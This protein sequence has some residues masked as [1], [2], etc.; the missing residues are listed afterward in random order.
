MTSPVTLKEWLDQVGLTRLESTFR[1]N[2]VDLDILFSLTDGDL[3]ELGLTLGD[4]KRVLAAAAAA[5]LA[6]SQPSPQP[7]SAAREEPERRQ[8]TMVFCDLVG[9][10]SLSGRLDPEDMHAVVQAYQDAC[11]GII[12]RYDGYVANFMGD[13]ILAY[14]GYPRAHEDDAARAAR[15]GL[16]IGAAIGKLETHAGVRLQVRV[17]IAT[18]VVVVNALGKGSALGDTPNLAARL[19]NL[20]RPGSVVIARATR[21]LLGEQF[22]LQ[23]IGTHT[24]KGFTE[25]VEAWSV[26]GLAASEDSAQRSAEEGLTPLVGREQEIAVLLD[27]WRLAQ[28]GTGQV[29]LLSGEPGIGKTRLLRALRGKLEALGA[30]TLRNQCSP[31]Y[32]NSAFWPSID[33]LEQTLQFGREEPPDSRLDKLEGFMVDRY[34]RPL[35]D[36]RF[37]A[38]LLSIPC[39]QRYGL[40]AMTPQKQKEETLRVLVDL[41]EAA[42]RQRPAL[43]V[44]EDMHWADPT[45][46]EVLDLLIERTKGA[47]LLLVLTYRPEFQP[48][49]TPQEHISQ[50]TL[51]RLDAAQS[52]AMVLGLTAGKPL[53]G[54]LP[55]RILTKTDGVPLF[56]EELTK[57]ILESGELKDT[58]DRYEY[59]GASHGITIPATLRALLTARLDRQ[60][61]VKEI[62]Q[63]GAAVG[64]K[65][66]Y[67]LVAAAAQ[68]PASRLEHALDGL[69]ESGLAFR[70]GA[71]SRAT[72]RFKHALVRDAAYDSLL[73]SRRQELHRRIAAAIEQAFPALAQSEPET[74]AHHHTQAG[75]PQIAIPLWQKAG[76]LAFGRMALAEAIS[77][78]ARGLELV[79]TLPSSPGRDASE[80]ALRIPLGRAWQALEGWANRGVWN[81]LHPALALAKSL[82]RS[83]ALLP[84]LWGLTLNVLTQG[85]IAESLPWVKETLDTAQATGDPDLLITAEVLAN[86]YHYFIGEPRAALM[87]H[88]KALALYDEE[89]HRRLADLLNHDPRT[90]VGVYSAICTWML[91][92]P[93]QAVRLCDETVAHARRRGHVFDLGFA[94]RMQA[95]LFDFRGEPERMRACAEECDR[96]GRDNSL[97]VLWALIARFACGVSLIRENK[98]AEGVGPLAA[99]LKF[100]DAAGGGSHG[101]YLKAVLAEGKAL[102]GD[103]DA[104]LALIDAQIAQIERPGWE[105]RVYYAEILRMKGWMLSLKGD[106]DGAERQYL[107]S[108]AWAREQGAKSWELRTAT[109]LARLRRAQGRGREAYDLLAP[110]HGWFTE[111]FDT[112]DLR[113]AGA[114]IKTLNRDNGG[115]RN[116]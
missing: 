27:R 26:E 69:V 68:L 17:G 32:V 102:L 90:R 53:P 75:Q 4:R 13:G 10:T 24:L 95:E 110:V 93:D 106:L 6:N 42:A 112:K 28:D 116:R 67:E 48:R 111:G 71:A 34:G 33:L 40:V 59:A 3:R 56:V 97:P 8:L 5:A 31:Y 104:A 12:A 62:A 81:N 84:I 20:A 83:D 58:G 63:I 49:W 73:R 21:R 85:R 43:I 100:W 44:F 82:G 105:E 16:E 51:A 57:S 45:S 89:G 77:H 1:Q 76:E 7:A 103:L 38:S 60:S 9:S 114:L 23:S 72:Y 115:E 98:A 79:A 109:S 39:E 29:V 66:S 78:L 70:Q 64:R 41:C 19:Q 18:G 30:Q 15:A 52:A 88:G 61:E 74:L 14:F 35:A 91:G 25:P 22:R 36:V 50:L 96:L 107:A 87:H 94:L 108:L 55:Q 101:P 65:F 99:G 92:Y 86:A 37:V 113:E 54:D 80:L 2:G 11:S 47:P 46:L